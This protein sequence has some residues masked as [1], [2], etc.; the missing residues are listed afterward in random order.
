MDQHGPTQFAAHQLSQMLLSQGR[1]E[2]MLASHGRA[3]D[4]LLQISTELSRMSSV[5]HNSGLNG[6]SRQGKSGL[7]EN[8]H[9]ETANRLLSI[10]SV[11]WQLLLWLLPRLTILWG[12]AHGVVGNI[13][14]MIS[15]GWLS[16][17][18]AIKALL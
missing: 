2:H 10:G 11:A 14:D 16:V 8:P 9:L 13:T 1:I 17:L 15:T 7:L 4:T 6:P 3:L 18:D 12:I 5:G